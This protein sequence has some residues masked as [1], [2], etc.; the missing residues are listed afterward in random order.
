MSQLLNLHA[1]EPVLPNREAH[2]L[3][4]RPSTNHH[5][6]EAQLRAERRVVGART[7]RWG[8]GERSAKGYKL[9][10]MSQSTDLMCSLTIT[11]NS[12]VLCCVIHL[13]VPKR[14]RCP[15]HKNEMVIM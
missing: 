2:V 11:V 14:V 13:E 4:K 7:V 5:T 12:T 3:Q 6:K 10:V 1:L 9:P 15:H 8:D